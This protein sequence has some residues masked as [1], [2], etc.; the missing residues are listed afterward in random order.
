VDDETAIAE[1]EAL[2]QSGIQ[3]VVFAWPAFWWLEHYTGLQT[4]LSS[5]GQPVFK[6]AHLIAFRLKRG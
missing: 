3:L 2:R 5:A 6:S 4:Y 1:L